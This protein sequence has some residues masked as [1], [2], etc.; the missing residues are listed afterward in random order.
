MVSL[1]TL[2]VLV[3]VCS[4]G[5]YTQGETTCTQED[6]PLAPLRGR[7][8]DART[9]APLQGSL[10]V[11]E[12]CGIYTENPD[13]SRGHPN[14]RYGGITGPDG[15]FEIAVP[16]GKAGLHTF[17]P[18]YRYGSLRLGDTTAPGIEVRAEPLLPEDKRP[19]VS[20][21]D[22]Q[23]REAS[24]GQTL[25]FSLVVR[26]ARPTDPLSEEI[27]IV[28]PTTQTGRAMNPP[29]RGV[30][31]RGFPDGT[32][33]ARLAAPARPGEYEYFIGVSSEQCITSDRLSVKVKVK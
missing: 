27:L 19:L 13:P 23:P 29:S 5:C 14:Y 2:L 6:A 24:P 21:F 4:L 3:S 26:A 1:R 30:Q 25:A 9:G 10:V 22:V 28:E 20:D 17:Q 18:G 11:V 33:T 31:G 7:V 12:L 8:F 15:T 32:W 16:R